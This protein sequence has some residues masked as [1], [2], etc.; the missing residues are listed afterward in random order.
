[1]GEGEEINALARAF[2]AM[3]ERIEVLLNELQQ[4][5]DN[6]AHELRTPIARIRVMAETTLKTGGDLGEYRE[7]AASV[8]DVCDDL[9]E[10]IGTMLEIAKTDSGTVEL[11]LV[12]LDLP[13]LVA[14]AVDLFTPLAEDKDI[15][16]RVLK[17]VHPMVFNGDLKKIQRIVANLLDNALKYTPVGGMVRLSTTRD[18]AFIKVEIADTGPGIPETDIPYVFD[19]FYRGDKSRTTAGSGLGLS[20][21]QALARA[22]NG[23][24]T[25][26]SSD[27]GTTFCL[28]LPSTSVQQ[29]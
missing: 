26:T 15:D 5:T 25:V 6:V 19:R 20:L 2:N 28:L 10:M 14:E 3:L 16:I 7:M 4:V 12:P 18:E 9:I 29:P 23:N 13:K 21:A 22:H 17:P 8:I 11:D 24:I 27:T 1:M